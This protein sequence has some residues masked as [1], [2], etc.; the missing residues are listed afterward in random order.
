MKKL[1]QKKK[2]RFWVGDRTSKPKDIHKN[3]ILIA[4]TNPEGRHGMGL[5]NIAHRFWGAEYYVGRGLSGQSYLLV[6]KNLTKNYF[7]EATG[8]TYSRYG[9]R[10]L[11]KQQLSD[12][13]EELFEVSRSMPTKSFI[14]AYKRGDSNLNGYSSEELIE[15]FTS[16]AKSETPSNIIFHE[17]WKAYFQR[18]NHEK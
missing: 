2:L 14:L 8:I 5:A 13:I 4:T 12:N 3:C 1:E 9:I 11:T 6:T 18:K 10:S 16:K 17:S 15:L 7:E